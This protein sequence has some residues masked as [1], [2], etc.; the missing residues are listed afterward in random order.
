MRLIRS[1]I[2]VTEDSYEY[3]EDFLFA[4]KNRIDWFFRLDVLDTIYD[5]ENCIEECQN[6]I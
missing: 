4:V 2:L 3:H 1:R 6:R 5:K